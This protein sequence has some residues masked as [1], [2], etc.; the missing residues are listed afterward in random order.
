MSR[1][2]CVIYVVENIMCERIGENRFQYSS[3]C[4]AFYVQE[5]NEW[6]SEREICYALRGFMYIR[7]SSLRS[8]SD[9]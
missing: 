7:S 3:N 4:N 5:T 6:E 2:V 9:V 8:G 1:N